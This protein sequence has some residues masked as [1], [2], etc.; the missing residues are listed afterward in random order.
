MIQTKTRNSPSM[1]EKCPS[2][3]YGVTDIF[4][5]LSISAVRNFTFRNLITEKELG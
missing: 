2:H 1:L 3:P 5:S 4:S